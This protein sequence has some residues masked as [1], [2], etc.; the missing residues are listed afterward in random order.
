[1]GHGGLDRSQL[2]QFVHSRGLKQGNR[3]NLPNGVRAGSGGSPR[4]RTRSTAGREDEVATGEADRGGNGSNGLRT[5]IAVRCGAPP[6]QAEGPSVKE[7]ARPSPALHAAG[8]QEDET[9]S[10]EGAT[11]AGQGGGGFGVPPRRGVAET[12]RGAPP[13]PGAEGPPGR[14]GLSPGS[15]RF[16]CTGGGGNGRAVLW[17]ECGHA[18][19]YLAGANGGKR[20]ERSAGEASRGRRHIGL[21]TGKDKSAISHFV[22]M[23]YRLDST[24]LAEETTREIY[25]KR[26]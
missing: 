17:S 8:A 10:V 2:E 26:K 13:P 15:A 11:E 20:I 24:P 16:R 7:E 3:T 21:A 4:S 18:G 6:A 23:R 14:H 5:T 1:M 19:G 9:G 25:V 12:V 22:R